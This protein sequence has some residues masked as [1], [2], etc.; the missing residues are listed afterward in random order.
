MAECD[1][2]SGKFMIED[3]NSENLGFFDISKNVIICDEHRKQI[4]NLISKGKI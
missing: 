1:F 2:C 4:M 3:V